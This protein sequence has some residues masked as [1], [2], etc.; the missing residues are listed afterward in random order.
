MSI[1]FQLKGRIEETQFDNG[2][3][4]YLLVTPAPDAYSQP[5]SYKLQSDN[6]IGQPGQE[7]VVNVRMSGFVRKK[8]YNDKKTQQPKVYW[9]DNVILKAFLAPSGK[10]A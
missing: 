9:E 10:P 6:Q 5:S 4:R 2:S 3:Y 7:V 8:P 1:D